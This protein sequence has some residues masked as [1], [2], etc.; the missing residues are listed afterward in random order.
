MQ[1]DAKSMKI[2]GPKKPRKPKIYEGINTKTDF[3]TL[4][5]GNKFAIANSVAK[6]TTVMVDEFRAKIPQIHDGV[7]LI[8][9]SLAM[10]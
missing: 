9:R 5:I 2:N 3:A 6:S 8:L 10:D 4:T 1:V 7:F